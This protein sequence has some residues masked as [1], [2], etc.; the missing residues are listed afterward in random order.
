MSG[1]FVRGLTGNK[2][3]VY[4]DGVRFTHAG[5]RGGVNTFLNL[6]DPAFLEGV[7]VLRGP[8]SAQYGSDALGGSIQL[9]THAPVVRGSGVNGHLNVSG[10]SAD[11]SFGS[12]VNASWSGPKLGAIATLTGRR[13]RRPADGRRHR[14]PQCGDAFPGR[15]LRPGGRR[16]DAR[17]RGST[18]TAA[19]SSCAWATSD[20]SQLTASYT[21]SQQDDGKRYDQLLGGDG[22]LIADLRNLMLDFGYL[23]YDRRQLGPARPPE[24]RLLVQQPARGARQP[25]RQRQSA[26]RHQPRVRAH[27]RARSA[28]ERHAAAPA[29]MRWAPGS[30]GTSSA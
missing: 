15:L 26:G 5:Q 11:D 30:T 14:L 20:T 19:T 10:G 17:T 9:R 6:N 3:N 16:P 27:H 7:E 25:G 8:S 28:G 24:H 12:S 4:V 23:R 29:G 1:I 18:S 13:A 21:R 22:N 2:V